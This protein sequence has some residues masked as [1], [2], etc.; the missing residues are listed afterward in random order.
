MRRRWRRLGILTGLLSAAWGL[1]TGAQAVRARVEFQRARG[2]IALG[3]LQPARRRLASL[4]A[5]RPGAMGGAVDYWLG[6]CEAN[7]GRPDEAL[8]AFG[9]VP[10]G[11][12]FDAQG[13]YIEAR[14]NLAHG[15]LRAAE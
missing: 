15:R 6:V 13:A 3:Q 8:R 7:L 5:A 1:V 14:A 9:R 11:F 10:A 12:V 2:E 4:A